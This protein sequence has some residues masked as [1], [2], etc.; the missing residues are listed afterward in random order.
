MNFVRQILAVFLSVFLASPVWAAENSKKVG[1]KEYPYFKLGVRPVD[2]SQLVDWEKECVVLSSD[3]SVPVRLEYKSSVDGKIKVSIPGIIR[4][5][6]EIVVDKCTKRALRVRKCGNGI[7][8]P[9]DWVPIGELRCLP[10]AVSEK[11]T[12]AISEE[13]VDPSPVS[14]ARQFGLGLKPGDLGPK[15]LKFEEQ[16][17]SAAVDPKQSKK[18]EV[19]VGA[20]KDE[21]K[22]PTWPYW[23]GGGVAAVVLAIILSKK[24]KDDPKT[25]GGPAGDPPN[26]V[27]SFSW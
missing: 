8:Q 27:F 24:D 20:D 13:T 21:N 18:A 23:V 16:K 25:I 11:P 5:G 19:G 22:S 15:K 26:S 3:D 9:T 6:E 10:A 14:L 4:P 1:D 17:A 12:V 7:T 2:D